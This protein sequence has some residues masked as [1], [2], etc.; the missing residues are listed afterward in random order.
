VKIL[1]VTRADGRIQ[2]KKTVVATFLRV[3]RNA[4]CEIHLPDPRVPLAQGMIT[5]PDQG[6]M[7]VEGEAGS[8]TISRTAVRQQRL[9]PGVPVAI[10]PY[11]LELQPAPEG[12]DARFQLELA[13]PPEVGAGLA[14]RTSQLTL[15]SLGLT[16]RWA[17]WLWALVVLGLFLLLP[18]GRVLDLPWSQAAQTAA[19]GDRFW[20]PGPLM[21]AH[22]PVEPKCAACHEAAFEH[23]KDR[24]CL[25]CHARVGHH[26]EP[27]LSPATLFGGARCSTCHREHK[28]VK[29]T[30]RDDDTFCVTCHKDLKGRAQGAV[31]ANAAD[32]A[33]DH[34]PFRLSL[35]S[36][37]GVLRVRQG[38]RP[39][40]ESSNLAFPHDKHLDPRG[41]RSPLQGRMTLQCRSCHEPDAARRGFQPISMA[42][43]CQECHTLQFEPAVT[44]REVPH[45]KPAEAQVMIEEFYANLALNGV[46][47]SFQKAFGVPG[48]GLLRRV[49]EPGSA[50]R[51]SALALAQRK[52]RKVSEEMFEVRVCKTCHAVTREKGRLAHRPGARD[53]HVDAAGAL[54]PQGA[55]A[56]QMH[57]LPRRRHVEEGERRVDAGHRDLPRVSRGI[58][59]RRGQ[60]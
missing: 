38:E 7:Y 6:F 54:Q 46:R 12:F 35:A 36:E 53:R 23:V 49:G 18:A 26:V 51:Q 27:R 5:H 60:G 16:K 41:V 9:E 52:A 45:G 56:G 40:I 39:L 33:R 37:S 31:A 1:L 32:F 44:T 13:S 55:R 4:S 15:G 19:F 8:Q 21:L 2:S 48:E 47:D 42:R 34:P 11:R 17:A 43:H 57:R 3:G 24:A 25:E 59:A 10:G 29:S 22:Q 50:E 30:H 58:E 28:G 14:S 20:N